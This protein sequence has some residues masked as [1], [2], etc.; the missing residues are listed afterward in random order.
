LQPTAVFWTATAIILIILCSWGALLGLVNVARLYK[1]KRLSWKEPTSTSSVQILFTFVFMIVWEV[2]T[3]IEAR[4]SSLAMQ[5]ASPHGEKIASTKLTREIFTILSVLL[6]ITAAMTIALVWI[7]V[8]ERAR[9]MTARAAES[10]IPG[11]RRFVIAFEVILSIAMISAIGAQYTSVGLIFGIISVCIVG[12]FYVF[13]YFRITME[14]KAVSSVV[15]ESSKTMYQGVI[16]EIRTI[17][18]GTALW[19]FSIFIICVVLTSYSLSNWKQ[20]GQPG[21]S[22]PPAVVAW[23]VLPLA[24]FAFALT[25]QIGLSKATARKIQA[26]KTSDMSNSN[27]PP[28]GPSGDKKVV[29]KT[30]DESNLGNGSFKSYPNSPSAAAYQIDAY[31]AT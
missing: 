1:V 4:D 14:L 22:I 13:G 15:N 11:T 19:A 6:V 17:A 31:Q 7:E 30:E 20:T 29:N 27:N 3:V 12:G 2:F 24:L 21:N 8:A 16:K 18:M 9:R 25:L 5:V 23:Q 10:V 28:N 26:G